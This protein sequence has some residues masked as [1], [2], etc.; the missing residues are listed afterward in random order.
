MH[1][2]KNSK[3]VKSGDGL[4][5]FFLFPIA[6]TLN[7]FCAVLY[8]IVLQIDLLLQNVEPQQTVDILQHLFSSQ[9]QHFAADLWKDIIIFF[10]ILVDHALD[11]LLPTSRRQLAQV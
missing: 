1:S 9:A 8:I 7:S 5:V 11:D 6:L 2:D 3:V 10:Q 4:E